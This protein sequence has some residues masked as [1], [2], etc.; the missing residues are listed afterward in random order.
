VTVTGQVL[1][2]QL[3]RKS[4]GGEDQPPVPTLYHL[5][6]DDGRKDRTTAWA[7]PAGLVGRC[8]TGDTVTVTARR[9]TRRILTAT[10]TERGE[11]GHRAG[12]GADDDAADRLVK[13][14]T[15]TG[16][17]SAFKAPAVEAS[18]LLTADEVTHALGLPVVLVDMRTLGGVGMI[19]FTT[20]DRK[21]VVL[22]MQVVDG[23]MGTLAWRTNSRGTPVAGIADGAWL[24]GNRAAVRVAETTVVFT[25]M[26]RGKGRTQKYP[27][28]LEQ[29]AAR[30]AAES[31]GVTPGGS[32]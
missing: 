18:S 21:R 6:I 3:C 27:L 29:A 2:V 31:G 32:A 11:R 30:V 20:A 4:S 17:A 7:L 14:M 24:N 26:G 19:H 13:A 10:L 15:E 16:V 23:A 25:L 28:L 9:W 1:W 5:A 22:M 8:E 12:G